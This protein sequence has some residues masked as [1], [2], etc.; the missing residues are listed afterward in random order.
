LEDQGI[1]GRM[2]SEWILGRLAGGRRMDPI[3]SG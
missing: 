3:G 1:D 2:G